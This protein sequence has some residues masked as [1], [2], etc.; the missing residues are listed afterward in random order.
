V[1]REDR[2]LLGDLGRLNTDLVPPAMRIIDDSASTEEHRA[3][4]ERLEAMARRLHAW[5]MRAGQVT[6]EELAIIS[7][8]ENTSAGTVPQRVL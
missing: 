5:A 7:D 6:D 8:K 3:F 1:I 2:L 4:A